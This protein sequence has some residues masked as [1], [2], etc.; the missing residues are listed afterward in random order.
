M[1]MNT[2]RFA[3]VV[4][5]ALLFV[6]VAK[7]AQRNRPEFI[8]FTGL[9][10]ASAA[11][12][13]D[14]HHFLVASDEDSRIRI[15]REDTPGPPVQ[16][17]DLRDFLELDTQHPETDIEAAARV[18]D[19]VYWITS[20]GRNAEGKRRVSRERFFATRILRKGDTFDLVP[21]GR[22]CKSLLAAMKTHPH[23]RKFDLSE[24]AT[25]APK[26][27]G[28]LNIE[29]LAAMP[30]GRMLIGFRNPVPE[31][32]ALIVP[33]LNP[34]EVIAGAEPRLGDP[35]LIDLGGLGIR[36]MV[37]TDR[38]CFIIGGPTSGKPQGK[39]FLW[40]GV[41]TTSRQIARLRGHNFNPEAFVLFNSP[42]TPK[43]LLLSDDG[44]RR[45]DGCPC[46]ELKDEGSRQFRAAWVDLDGE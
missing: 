12:A 25:K 39:V 15:Y 4:I 27:I 22:P 23:L 34:K 26:D 44:T 46:K 38:G 37:W 45:I 17:F 33:L 11:T 28:G 43:A 24:A 41:S 7:C 5:S 20:H 16:V 30:D 8:V 9:C 29:G 2:L 36:D 42:D 1:F 21:E 19:I 6:G 13:I 32:R 35:I 40:D 14:Q 18:D 3:A 10:D 31:S